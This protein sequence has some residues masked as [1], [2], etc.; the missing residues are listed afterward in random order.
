METPVSENNNRI[1]AWDGCVNVRDLGGLKTL[2][3]GRT[4][5]GAVVRSDTPARLTE[6][7]WAALYAH[8]IRTIISLRTHGLANDTPDAAAPLPGV[9]TLR[10]AVEDFTDA[11]FV[12]QWV[13]TDLWCT[14]LYYADVLRRWPQKHAEAVRAVA[15]AQPGGVLVHCGRGYDRTGIV[16]LLLL[17]L[18]GVAPDEI[19]ADYELS[20]DEVRD[21]LLAGRGTSSR[22]VIL[23]ML[24][25]LDVAACLQQGGLTQAELAAVRARLLEADQE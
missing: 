18:A 24:E 13:D 25:E 20:R 12:A 17:A 5:W 22:Q 16:T 3:G 1:L 23:S 9:V 19:V 4:R 14:P 6:A 11:E 8:G 10:V 7:G 21:K 2:A 15:L